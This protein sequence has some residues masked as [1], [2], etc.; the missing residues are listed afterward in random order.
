MSLAILANAHVGRGKNYFSEKYA[1]EE[2]F[3][4]E[5]I[6]CFDGLEGAPSD[7][8]VIVATLHAG[9]QFSNLIEAKRKYPDAILVGWHWDNHVNYLNNISANMVVD[10][11]CESHSYAS[12]YLI[13]PIS[14]H[15]AHVP[16]CSA[17]WLASQVENFPIAG[18]PDR[19][20]RCL[21]NYVDYKFS[22]RTE[23]LKALKHSVPEAHCLIMDASDRTRYFFKSARDRY[24]EWSGFMSTIIL[25]VDRDLSTRV[26]DA[27]VAGLVLVVPRSIPDFD[28]I[29]PRAD[30][31]KIGVVKIDNF[32]VRTVRLA[33][34]AA[35][36]VFLQ[37]GESGI[38]AR[39]ALVL[40]NH[41]FVHRIRDII[42]LLREVGCGQKLLE[43]TAGGDSRGPGIAC[44]GRLPN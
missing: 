40:N 11:W 34:L 4:E 25:P 23:V 14:A 24:L 15:L 8:D 26:F 43:W 20:P 28:R 27:L 13:N 41:M 37:M 22:K 18:V 3:Q 21:V 1:K 2:V 5:K 7:L 31:E 44:I 19:D 29:I 16:A 32:D 17:Q 33:C 36:K 39:R 9:R 35:K 6:I 38:A 30:Q 42:S 12:D 10:A